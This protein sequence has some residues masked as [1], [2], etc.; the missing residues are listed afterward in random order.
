MTFDNF[1]VNNTIETNDERR[2]A[3]QDVR[4]NT[5]G[6]YDE[7]VKLLN[8]NTK[9]PSDSKVKPQAPFSHTTDKN[10]IV[11]RDKKYSTSEIWLG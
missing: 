7:W 2:L 3:M 8:R 5:S 4:A 6:R 10:R 1:F 11:K 9:F